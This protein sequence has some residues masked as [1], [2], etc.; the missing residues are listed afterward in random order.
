MV[1]SLDLD[2]E[3]AHQ[4]ISAGS[5]ERILFSARAADAEHI[6]V[7]IARA[8]SAVYTLRFIGSIVAFPVRR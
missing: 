4:K 8:K 2:R 1:Q 5:A 3:L 7:V 6:A